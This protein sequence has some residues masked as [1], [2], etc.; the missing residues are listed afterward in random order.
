MHAARLGFLDVVNVL[1]AAGASIQAANDV[2]LLA[3]PVRCALA[4]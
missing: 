2:S 4:Q 1:Y 3:E